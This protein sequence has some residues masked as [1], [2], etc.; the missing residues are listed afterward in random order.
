MKCGRPPGRLRRFLIR[1]VGWR[2]KR[3]G[4]FFLEEPPPPDSFV[5]EPRR[6]TPQAPGGSIALDLPPESWEPR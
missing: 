5:R 2:Q 6:P 4:D 1:L 3:C